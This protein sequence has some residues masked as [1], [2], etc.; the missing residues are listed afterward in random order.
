MSAELDI[1]INGRR[2]QL[3]GWKA[4]IVSAALGILGLGLGLW[5]L[6]ALFVGSQQM[7]RW[8]FGI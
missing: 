2:W 1:Q 3:S 4:T 6:I 7:I 8:M 5:C